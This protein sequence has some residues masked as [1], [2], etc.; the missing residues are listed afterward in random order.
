M[1][2]RVQH[3]VDKTLGA[4]KPSQG[5]A[6][7]IGPWG[8]TDIQNHHSS[9]NS[10]SFSLPPLQ[11]QYL[12]LT[13]SP[14]GPLR[15][16]C[17]SNVK[18]VSWHLKPLDGYPPCRFKSGPRHQKWRGV[19]PNRDYPFLLL[20]QGPFSRPSYSLFVAPFVKSIF[21]SDPKVAR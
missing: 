5:R 4:W 2:R 18:V 8:S 17:I 19:I 10:I 15:E 9:G 1:P 13:P 12:S 16:P 21:K 7:T 11:S 6:M 3:S 14:R 20:F